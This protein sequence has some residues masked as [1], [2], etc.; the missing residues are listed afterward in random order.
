M[1][2]RRMVPPPRAHVPHPRRLG[3]GFSLAAR[4]AAVGGEEGFSVRS[5]AEFERFAT[6]LAD[7]SSLTG[8]VISLVP[9]EPAPPLYRWSATQPG[10]VEYDISD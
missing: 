7:R 9:Q 1:D 4:F 5:R 6:K 2:R 8:T 3:D 10:S